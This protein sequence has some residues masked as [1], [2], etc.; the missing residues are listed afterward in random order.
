MTD[1]RISAGLPEQEPA[2]P[3]PPER[4][5]DHQARRLARTLTAGTWLLGAWEDTNDDHC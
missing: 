3:I 1:P 5:D 4:D 2:G